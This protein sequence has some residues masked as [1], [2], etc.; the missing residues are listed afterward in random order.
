ML[1]L[2]GVLGSGVASPT[3]PN[4]YLQILSPSSNQLICPLSLYCRMRSF[5]KYV[6]VTRMT[7]CRRRPDGNCSSVGIQS[8]DP[9][10]LVPLL[11][12]LLL[13]T[14]KTVLLGENGRPRRRSER[15]LSPLSAPFAPAVDG[16]L[17]QKPRRLAEPRFRPNLL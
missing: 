8:S 3:P 6:T 12:S 1:R 15:S 10:I 16:V 17:A 4:V 13:A 2:L 14:E 7:P 11:D 5:V 9:L